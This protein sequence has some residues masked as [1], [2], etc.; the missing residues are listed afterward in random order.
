MA[1]PEEGG[2]AP[3]T[4][5]PTIITIDDSPDVDEAHERDLLRRE[6]R[7]EENRRQRRELFERMQ[8]LDDDFSVET[9]GY[10]NS[11]PPALLRDFDMSVERDD[12]HTYLANIIQSRRRR[13]MPR[14]YTDVPR[15]TRNV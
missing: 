10:R 6:Q 14:T 8:Q 5:T 4:T 13:T 2:P 15:Y 7:M 1:L 11:L 12:I 3:T 9:T